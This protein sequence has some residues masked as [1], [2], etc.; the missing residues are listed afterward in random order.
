MSFSSCLIFNPAA[1]PTERESCLQKIQEHLSPDFSL[2][3]YETTPE[4]DAEELA[5]AAIQ[6]G[7]D[8]IFAAG[9]D[10][11]VSGVAH[12]LLGT[13]IPLGIIP[14]GTANAFANALGIPSDLLSAC[15]VIRRQNTRQVDAGQCNDQ[16]MILFTS[17]GFGAEMSHH[18]DREAKDR[19]GIMAYFFAALQ[20]FQEF[21]TFQVQLTADGH[22]LDL[23]AT[24]ITIANTAPL[25]SLLAQGPD[26]LIAD[27]GLF[28]V[29]IIAPQHWTDPLSKFTQGLA[30]SHDLLQSA[31]RQ[32]NAQRDDITCFR[33]KQISVN[34]VPPQK[35]MIDGEVIGTTP[36][37]VQCISQGLTLYV[38]E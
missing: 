23:E 35:V 11:T 21:D 33:A 16:A 14:T 15:Q 27:D 12:A 25:T 19:W 29:T 2:T 36:A 10:G 37:E 28:D 20:N 24:A 34:T 9:G 32:Q 17:I 30:I 5:Q 26:Q 1:G 38:N 31:L 6:K 4:R 3:V 8:C 7:F 13:D 22:S 18:A